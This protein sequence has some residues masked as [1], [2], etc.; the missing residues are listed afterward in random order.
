MADV[1]LVLLLSVIVILAGQVDIALFLAPP[2]V[3]AMVP[4]IVIVKVVFVILGGQ[5]VIALFL[6]LPAG[7]IVQI[8]AVVIVMVAVLVIQIGLV[9]I[10]QSLVQPTARF[11]VFVMVMGA[12]FATLGGQAVIAQFLNHLH[13]PQNQLLLLLP[14]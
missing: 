8:M 1:I 9:L 4:V 7:I 2:I 11:M 13:Q 12:V 10:V 14:V 6:L 3:Q 5:A